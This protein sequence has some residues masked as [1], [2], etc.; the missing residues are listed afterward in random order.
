[1]ATLNQAYQSIANI[2]LWF[3]LQ[4]GDQLVLAD[5]PSIIPMRWSYFQTSW[6]II[7]PT[8]EAKVSSYFN[9]DLFAQ[10]LKDFTS[11]VEIQRNSTSVINPLSSSDTFFRFYAVWDN[12]QIN[13]INLSVE[14]QSVINSTITTVK[15][16]TKNDFLEL[17]SNVIDYRDRQADALGLT[18][19]TYN[20]VFNRSAV[21]VTQGNPNVSDI[22]YL[23]TLQTT[24]QS[25]D[26]ILANLFPVDTAVDP[27]AIA[28][29]NANNP[30]INIGQYSSGQLVRFNYGDDLESI[31]YRY[32]GDPN[33]WVD[34]AIANGL[35]PPYIDEIGSAVPLQTNG[36]GN[37]INISATDSS[38]V[39]NST[40]FYVNQHVVLQSNTQP[41]PDQRVVTNIVQIPATGDLVITLNGPANLSQYTT[42]ASAY[43]R[44]FAPDT[45]NSSQF[46]L[47]PSQAPLPNQRQETVP[48]FLAG[49]AEDEKQAGIDLLLD[50]NDDLVFTPNNDINLSYGLNNA[51][52]AMRL[53]VVTELGELRYHQGFGLVNVIGNKNNNLEAVKNAIV[54]SLT[55]QVSQD[56]RFNRIESLNV[57]YQSNTGQAPAVVI[58]MEVRLSGSSN[59]V[60]PISFSVNYT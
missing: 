25:V 47:I 37:D 27:F 39:D 51:I 53:K 32:L 43:V 42:A 29:A 33:R 17:Q 44:I 38:G 46:I 55:T 5:V 13:S 1:M 16:Y 30:D 12:I 9:P 49:S 57:L 40:K 15:N 34:I 23:E 7:L 41:F 8:L 36:S 59:R 35:Q 21:A 6:N 19:A 22:L 14:E 54:S 28:R 56:P 26:F 58:N 4:T 24:I 2:N 20:T 31:A 48:W 45:I 18:D 3:K 11:F 60:V 52:Q 50:Q 10:Q